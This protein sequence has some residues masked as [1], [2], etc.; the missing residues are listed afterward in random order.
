M[1]DFID[2]MSKE[3]KA[4]LAVGEFMF[5]FSALEFQLN[6]ALRSLLNLGLLEA[7]LI[8]SNVDVR[9]KVYIVKTAVDMR[10]IKHAE[11]LT[12]AKSD[13]EAI[14]KIAE[15]RNILAHNNFTPREDGV[16]FFYVKAKG[17]LA[18]PDELWTFE[19]FD[20]LQRQMTTLSE[21][22]TEIAKRVTKHVATPLLNAIAETVG[23]ENPNL[24]PSLMEVLF[25]RAKDD[26]DADEPTPQ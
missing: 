15:K 24:R 20:D 11:W 10:P 22:V 26:G 25:A 14:I 23:N 17:K 13:L 1:P 7:H 5:Y 4:F 18:L 2:G 6:L 3:Q 16:E 19:K 8:T 21:A 12:D 9:T